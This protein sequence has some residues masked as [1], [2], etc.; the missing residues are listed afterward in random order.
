MIDL[1]AGAVIAATARA[2]ALGA[3][4]SVGVGVAARPMYKCGQQVN[5]CRHTIEHPNVGILE[6][7]GRTQRTEKGRGRRKR[8]MASRAGK[9]GQEGVIGTQ[10]DDGSRER[11]GDGDGTHWQF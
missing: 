5:I 7:H 1:L 3:A 10:D 11:D 8:K 4:A 2:H 9:E 6:V